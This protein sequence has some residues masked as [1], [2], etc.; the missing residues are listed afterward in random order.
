M[1]TT[2]RLA[3]TFVLVLI[4]SAAYGQEQCDTLILHPN[5]PMVV[6]VGSVYQNNIY[7]RVCSVNNDHKEVIPLKM[8]ADIKYYRGIPQSDSSKVVIPNSGIS[9]AQKDLLSAGEE[10]DEVTGR[11][12][13]DKQLLQ[14]KKG[15]T[16]AIPEWFFRKTDI[17]GLEKRLKK[18][19][20]VKVVYKKNGVQRKK[21]ISKLHDITSS[22]LVLERLGS[23]YNEIPRADVIN[24]KVKRKHGLISGALGGFAVVAALA[25]LGI[26]LLIMLLIFLLSGGQSTDTSGVLEEDKASPWRVVVILLVVGGAALLASS[27]TTINQPFSDKWD[28]QQVTEDMKTEEKKSDDYAIGIER[29]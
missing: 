29:P 6:I 14:K 1:S 17:A 19:D 4:F 13:I 15:N 25:L 11:I 27:P 26:L 2:L 12:I 18:G 21:V 10:M 24:I 8:V 20:K 22:H 28:V 7:C 9:E 23:G 16:P 3:A 5:R